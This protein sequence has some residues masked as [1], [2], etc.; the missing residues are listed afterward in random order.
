MAHRSRWARARWRGWI[1]ALAGAAALGAVGAGAEPRC[2]TDAAD[3]EVCLERPAERIVSLS[4]GATELLFA[5][6]A[7][8]RVV[9]AVS[10]SDYPEEAEEIPRVGG[11]A[12]FDLERLV[13]KDPDL[14]IGWLSGNPI[15][16]LEQLEGMGLTI[17]YIEPRTFEDV[18]VALRQLGRL[19]G[20]EETADAEAQ[21]FRAGIEEV[22]QRY[23]DA[24]PVRLF[25]QIWEDPVMTINSDHLIHQA[26]ELC[27]GENVFGHLN[28]L[29]PR[30]DR[31]VV[32]EKD[33]QAIVAG[34]MGEA[35]TSWLEGWERFEDLQAVREGHLYFVNPS[36][37]QRP[38]PR[39]LEGIHRLCEQLDKVR[40]GAAGGR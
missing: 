23:A 11:L 35:D 34:G 20:T 30:L 4:P 24:V 33:P 26:L 10:H 7:G 32:L 28:R 13:A 36:T 21:R 31:E 16:Q 29:T 5:A 6:G 27:G 18:E 25:Y 38:T 14:V 40:G 2:V 17:H 15:E 8:E 39:I 37:I 3:R 12:R 9:G 22:R 19:A 1:A